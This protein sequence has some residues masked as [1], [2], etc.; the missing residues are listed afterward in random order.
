MPNAYK[1][2]GRIAELG[3]S[4]QA[5]AHAMGMSQCTLS[6]KINGKRPFFLDEAEKLALLLNIQPNEFGCFFFSGK[7]RSAILEVSKAQNLM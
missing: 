5:L 1:L 2:K 6:Q 4:Q 3:T 7:L